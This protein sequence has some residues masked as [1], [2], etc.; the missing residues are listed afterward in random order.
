MWNLFVCELW[1]GFWWQFF[2]HNTH[3]PHD[4]TQ[5]ALVFLG[6]AGMNKLSMLIVH[7]TAV[8]IHGGG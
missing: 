1:I 3:G 2:P 8:E 5:V 7:V 6:A 4:I